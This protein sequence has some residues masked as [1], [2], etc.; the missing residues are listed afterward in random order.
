MSSSFAATL[1]ASA[2]RG[3]ARSF[4]QTAHVA[5]LSRQLCVLPLLALSECI[6]VS[7]AHRCHSA[8]RQHAMRILRTGWCVLHMPR[9]K[10]SKLHSMQSARKQ[11]RN[12]LRKD[13]PTATWLAMREGALLVCT[14]RQ[15][16]EVLCVLEMCDFARKFLAMHSAC[17]M[18]D[19]RTT[20][21]TSCSFAP[22][23]AQSMRRPRLS[24][25]A[26]HACPAR[27]RSLLPQLRC[28]PRR[29]QLS[30]DAQ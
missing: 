10:L 8:L 19:S 30:A 11:R 18:Q 26:F 9:P 21:V 15:A 6:I 25:A 29:A 14:S 22:A 13:R 23:T 28:S 16:V 1:R 4:F 27:P 7:N 2:T 3:S 5:T 24:P 20:Q 17:H 12:T